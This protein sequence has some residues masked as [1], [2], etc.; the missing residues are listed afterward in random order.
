MIP[1]DELR[2]LSAARLLALWRD[3]QAARWNGCWNGWHPR[4]SPPT[5][6]L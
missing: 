6:R 4:R 1:V 3:S 2:P 5:R